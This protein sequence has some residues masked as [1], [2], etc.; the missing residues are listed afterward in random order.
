M[1]YASNSQSVVL[2]PMA[3][4]WPENLLEIQILNPNS[5]LLNQKPCGWAKQ[6]LQRSK[7]CESPLDVILMPT[8][9]EDHCSTQ[10][11][12]P[13]LLPFLSQLTCSEQMP[14]ASHHNFTR[15]WAH[16]SHK[17]QGTGNANRVCCAHK[18]IRLLLLV[19]R[20]L[21]YTVPDG[22]QPVSSW[23]TAYLSFFQ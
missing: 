4:A 3:W 19:Q 2:A 11:I 8:K 14:Q 12:S 9:S 10:D 23:T 1:S 21:R 16:P 5:D 17:E 18:L 20:V 15:Y 6:A 22:G 13:I 7:V